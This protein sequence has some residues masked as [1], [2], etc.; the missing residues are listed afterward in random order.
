MRLNL[1]RM[2]A[3]N[4]EASQ[5]VF[6][7][8]IIFILALFSSFFV[9][10]FC[11]SLSRKTLK[12]FSGSMLKFCLYLYRSWISYFRYNSART[13]PN[14]I[15]ISIIISGHKSFPNLCL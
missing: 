2:D 12:N 4:E 14:F 1:E 9:V 3:S 11:S 10:S 15:N 5:L 7:Y 6:V 13:F 8:L